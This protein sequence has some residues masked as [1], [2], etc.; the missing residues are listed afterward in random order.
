MN[1]AHIFIVEDEK[2]IAAI[3]NDY[4]QR[5]GYQTT[6]LYDG[7]NVVEQVQTK[8]PDLILLDIMLPNVSGIDICKALREFSE[9]PIIMVTARIEEIDRLLGLDVGADDYIC[10][11]FSPRE[12][13]ARVNTVLRRTLLQSHPITTGL[14][15]DNRKLT[16]TLHG[17]TVPLTPNEFDLLSRLA[18]QPGR[19]YGRQQLLD[20]INDEDHDT[21]ERAVDSHIK[22]IRKKLI[23]IAPQSN[24]IHSVY[25][26]GYKFDPL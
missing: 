16:V 4:L 9:V 13:V 19:V 15:I 12:V 3:H 7:L 24:Y 20:V 2:K 11:P 25:G 22:N 8:Q 26:V 21:N 1:K 10:K 18:S 23:D 6:T 5:A 17:H 14:K